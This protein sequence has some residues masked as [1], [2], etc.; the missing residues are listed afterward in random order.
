MRILYFHQYFSTPKGANGTRSYEFAK[1]LVKK[2][3]EVVIICLATDRSI[4][5]LEKEKF[6]N[7]KR[8]GLVE[9]VR[10]IEF[11]IN[12]SNKF[13]ML[14]RSLVFYNFAL[15]STYIAFKEKADLIFCTS[16]P[17]T[18]TIP[19]IILKIVKGTPF[20]LEIRDLWPE[21]PKA[22]K[23]V[24][25]KYI[26][27]LLSLLE[28]ISYKTADYC[29]ALAPGISKGITRRGIDPKKVITI[30]NGCDLDLFSRSIKKEKENLKKVLNLNSKEEIYFAAFT[31][32]I[33][34]ANGLD[35]VL[36]AG[37][38]LIKKGRNDIHFILI[39]DGNC[40]TY[41]K[42]RVIKENIYNC[43]FLDPIPKLKLAKLLSQSIDIGLM[44]L[45]DIPE[46]YNGTSPNKFFDYISSGLPVL[47]NYPGW[48]SK[49]IKK[50]NIGKITSPKN[51]K[52]FA[53]KIIK[54][55]DNSDELYKMS[56]NSRSLA[57]KSFSREKLS[58][59]FYKII[60]SCLLTKRIKK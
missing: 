32:A 44:I 60:E 40:K 21:L 59:Q 25:N 4:T 28:I 30:P 8:E 49:L 16:T 26:L 18:V 24:K 41:L 45:D 13:G 34:I 33:G 3:Y 29:I 58:D 10:V 48:L 38:E 47:I 11:E 46:F 39:G 6:I 43:H 9:G 14:G 23:I 12:Y 35:D 50:N 17:L 15:K 19:G 36:D 54:M 22:M 1:K 57:E 27:M 2:G 52:L 31:G 56:F 53:E 55:C 51:P 37:I 20:V 5:G 7:G 42:K